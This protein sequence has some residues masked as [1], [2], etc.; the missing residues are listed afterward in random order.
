MAGGA[1]PL[2]NHVLSKVVIR[3]K[4][5]RNLLPWE[6]KRNIKN[7]DSESVNCEV[8]VDQ[9]WGQ[10]PPKRGWV[11]NK[12]CGAF[13]RSIYNLREGMQWMETRNESHNLC[14]TI[15]GER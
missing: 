4:D 1:C 11:P 6:T 2:I 13:S 8:D 10:S 5:I 12:H 3:K 9:L 14:G 15:I 7:N